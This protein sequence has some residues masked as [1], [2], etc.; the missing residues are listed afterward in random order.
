[1]FVNTRG[2][3]AS[4]LLRLHCES[5]SDDHGDITMSTFKQ[6]AHE[7][8]D[9]LPDDAGWKDLV[10]EA[11]II[12]DIEVGLAESDAG[13]GVDTATLRRQFDLPA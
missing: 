2:C 10:Y 5:L 13:L 9:H 12:Q 3:F 1:M 6:Q 4:H 8:I 11:S 7:L